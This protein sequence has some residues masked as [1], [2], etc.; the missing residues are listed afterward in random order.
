MNFLKDQGSKFYKNI[1]SNKTRILKITVTIALLVLASYL[2]EYFG[3]GRHVN[4]Y[5]FML[6]LSIG[7]LILVFY[8]LRKK[9][10]EHPEFG[11]LAVALICGSL[12]AIS[13][14]KYFV[15]WDEQIHYKHA[16]KLASSVAPGMYSRPNTTPSSYSIQEQKQNDVYVDSKYKKPLTKS[17][18]GKPIY[19]QVGYLPSIIALL[20]SYV[21]HLP[22]HITFI[23]G[24]WMNLFFYALIVFFAIRKLKSGKMILAVIA[25]FPTAIFLA[26]NYNYDSWVTAFTMLG[27]AYL[28]SELQQ[29]DKKTTVPEMA[30]MVGSFVIGLGPKAIYFPLMFLLFLLKEPKFVSQKQYRIYLTATI[31]AILFVASTFWLPFLIKGPGHGDTHRGGSA[32]NATE[33]VRFILSEPV[34]YTK[35]LFNFMKNYINPLNASGLMTFFA[36]LGMMKGF[37]VVL[38]TLIITVFTDKNQYDKH[39]ATWKI[40]LWV[41]GIFLLIVSLICTGLY[42]VFTPVR[43]LNFA[44]VQPRYLI[45]LIFPLLFI[46]GSSRFKNKLNRNIYNTVIFGIMAVVF[47]QGTWTLII[48]R[49]Y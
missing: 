35:I 15:S 2:I 36:Y 5:R 49:Y 8:A 11:F 39:T 46:L 7:A 13:E 27:L 20:I 38:G 12:L 44:G 43:S 4:Q 23:F 30:V 18:N 3:F 29:P 21:V 48:S 6:I 31:L 42:V 47:L 32:I 1:V 14:P 17:G 45:P 19:S 41:I 10:G 34:A 22:Y 16:E 37:F 40:R 9:I 24:R 33:Q 26:S 25:L 28:F